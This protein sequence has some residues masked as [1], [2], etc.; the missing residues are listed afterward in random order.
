MDAARACN[1]SRKCRRISLEEVARGNPG[2][3]DERT[4]SA[5]SDVDEISLARGEG[6]PTKSIVL[7]NQ[8]FLHFHDNDRRTRA[9]SPPPSPPI[10]K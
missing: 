7:R 6:S 5:D 10:P 1:R 9:V 4:N 3:E 8:S 2:R